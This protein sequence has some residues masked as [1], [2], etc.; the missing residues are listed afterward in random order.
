MVPGGANLRPAKGAHSDSR[1]EETS[2][3]SLRENRAGQDRHQVVTEGASAD[4]F[5]EHLAHGRL[6][7]GL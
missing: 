3:P 2:N 1:A 6:P 5:R 7:S 4:L